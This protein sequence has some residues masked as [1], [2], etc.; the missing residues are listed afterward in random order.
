MGE[1]CSYSIEEEEEEE[2]EGSAA[3][4][5]MGLVEGFEEFS[6]DSEEE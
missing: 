2:D 3:S 5:L 1:D 4:A 6:C